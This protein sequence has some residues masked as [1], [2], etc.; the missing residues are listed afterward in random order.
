MTKYQD[1]NFTSPDLLFL[2]IFLKFHFDGKNRDSAH[3]L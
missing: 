1:Q 3:E 2:M